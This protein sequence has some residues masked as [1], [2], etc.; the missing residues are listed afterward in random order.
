VEPVSFDRAADFYDAT[1]G[2]P[3]RALDALAGMLA[4]ELSGRGRSLEIGVGTGRIALPLHDR[5]VPLA[6]TDISEPMMRKLIE[7]SGGTRPFPLLLADATRLPFADAAFGAV[8]ACH[9]LHLI[10][11]WRAAVDE[12]IRVLRPGGTLLVDFG[13]RPSTDRPY[14]ADEV[15]EALRR[16]GLSRYRYG[17]RGAGEVI[18]YLGD[19]IRVRD[20]PA[21]SVARTRTL[22]DRVERLENQIESSTWRYTAE[23]MRAA[24]S[25]IRAWAARE[26]ISLD[27]EVPLTGTIT[28]HAFDLP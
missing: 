11:G 9:V 3:T 14:W 2:L 12:A 7:N 18:A 26:G 6:G 25:D 24:G 16:H 20:L 1:R 21:I 23:Q 27:E 4:A 22:R 19:R 28:W 15:Q 8:I 17:A 13:E 5:G 10:P